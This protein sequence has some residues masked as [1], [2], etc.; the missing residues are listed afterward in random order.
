MAKKC[1]YCST[2]I[3]SGCVVDMC[4][5]CMYKV[6]G[7]KMSRAIIEG[8]ER[9]RGV[10]NLELGRI[11]EKKDILVVEEKDIPEQVAMAVKELEGQINHKQEDFENRGGVRQAIEPRRNFS[12]AMKFRP[13]E[14]SVEIIEEIES[15]DESE[16]GNTDFENDIEI[17]EIGA[18]DLLI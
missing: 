13:I 2:E 1:I 8:M 12:E 11:G 16:N 3:D 17:E 6:W 14:S 18:E 4:E 7:E 9:E 5:S 10:G 15:Y